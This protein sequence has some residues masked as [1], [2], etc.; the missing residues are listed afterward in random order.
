MYKLPVDSC[1]CSLKPSAEYDDVTDDV[2]NAKSSAESY[3]E[4]KTLSFQLIHATSFCNRQLQI[5]TAG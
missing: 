3:C 1:D 5:P 4:C 2:I